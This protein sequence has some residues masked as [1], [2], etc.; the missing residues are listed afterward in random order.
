MSNDGDGDGRG[1]GRSGR[2]RPIMRV[3]VYSLLINVALFT[4]KLFLSTVSGSLALKA[5][6]LHSLVDVFD[7]AALILGLSISER[8]SKSF[9]YGLYKVENVF[10]IFIALMIFLSAFEIARHAVA[11]ETAPV[12]DDW[13]IFAVAALIPVPLL[14]GLYEVRAGEAANSPGLVAD[15]TQFKVDALTESLVLFALIGQ[16]FGLPLDRA[17]ALLIAF[18]VVRG[19]WEILKSGMRVLLDASVD[20]ATLEGI[21]ETIL[22]DPTVTSVKAVTARNSGRYIFVEAE[23]AFRIRDLRRAHQR[24]KLVEGEIRKKF[25]YVARV[26]IHYE[27][28]N[29]IRLRYAIPLAGPAGEVSDHFG[30][31]PFF[32][33]VDIDL[34]Q[35]AMLRQEVVANPH[36]DLTKGRGLKVAGFL[37]GYKPDAVVTRE[38]LT[39]KGPGY[40]FAEAGVETLQTDE[41]RLETVVDGTLKGWEDPERV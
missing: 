12:Y 36:L 33:L 29:K 24:S 15:G 25:P 7:S 17:A 8:K 41:D 11:V 6:A 23:V 27:P 19:G 9:P 26:L 39:G 38:D 13:V 20:P 34:R 18:F 31:A 28:E 1:E 22:A 3:A 32:A 4:I 2:S 40:V 30:E 37:L 14:F 21:R 5:D 35:R 10:S 16:R